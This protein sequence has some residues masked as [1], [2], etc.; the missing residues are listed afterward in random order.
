MNRARVEENAGTAINRNLIEPELTNRIQELV[1]I[2]HDLKL[3]RYL[4]GTP[5]SK[6]FDT[7]K[8]EFINEVAF[9]YH[10][11]NIIVDIFKPT[12]NEFELK[13][14]NYRQSL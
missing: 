3:L 8:K 6:D 2:P 11:R 5:W 7:W 9:E 14:V 12:T 4:S 10:V 13:K 1:P